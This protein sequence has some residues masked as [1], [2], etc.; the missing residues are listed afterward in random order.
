MITP[1]WR[2]ILATGAVLVPILLAFVF[3]AAIIYLTASPMMITPFWRLILATGAVL[4][5]IAN[6][7]KCEAR[8]FNSTASFALSSCGLFALKLITAVL[9]LRV[10][11]TARSAGNTLSIVASELVVVATTVAVRAFL[12]T[13][14]RAVAVA[15]A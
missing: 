1:F 13:P 7:L 2:L 4:V 15:V 14:V 9:A 3:T 12:V 6:L 11:R 8:P 5:P 10:A